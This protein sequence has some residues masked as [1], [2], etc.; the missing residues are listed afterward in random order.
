MSKQ[1]YLEAY[2]HRFV[3]NN[4]DVNKCLELYNNASR[5]FDEVGVKKF[6]ISASLDAEAVSAYKSWLES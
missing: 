4:I 5:Y 1:F 3:I 6:R 2:I